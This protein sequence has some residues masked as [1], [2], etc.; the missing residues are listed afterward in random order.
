MAKEL[1]ER[2]YAF[3]AGLQKGIEHF[4][5]LARQA[6]VAPRA[7]VLVAKPL[8]WAATTIAMDLRAHASALREYMILTDDEKAAKDHAAEMAEE[9]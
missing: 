3:N 1:N 8:A 6:D 2:G 4:E 9:W 7:C 5:E